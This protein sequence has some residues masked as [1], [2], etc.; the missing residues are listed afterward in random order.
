MPIPAGPAV[1]KNLYVG[2][3]VSFVK[4]FATALIALLALVALVTAA[5]SYES[6]GQP[7]LGVDST[8]VAPNPQ[9]RSP[10][11]VGPGKTATNQSSKSR[12]AGDPP[13]SPPETP[14]NDDGLSTL[15]I[16]GLL[17]GLFVVAVLA[18]VLTDDDTRAPPRTGDNPPNE[19]RPPTPP[20]DPAY[21]PPAENGVVS[22]WRR[23]S[24]RVDTI[25][26]SSTPGEAASVAVE[27]G[28]PSD[29]V[30]GLTDQFESVRYG[31]E[32]PS[33]EQERRANRLADRLDGQ[34]PRQDDVTGG[35]DA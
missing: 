24:D 35:D 34:E 1:G 3:T 10:G 8:S 22:A 7:R 32:S 19:D 16:V 2:L 33:S 31:R 11:G 29:T 14:D 23:L 13:K 15:I 26:D 25:D 17:G 18:V 12:E 21:E 6:T 4:R 30:E 20:V 27:R 28:F 9:D 5:G